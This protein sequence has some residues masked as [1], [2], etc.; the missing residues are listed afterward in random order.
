[1]VADNSPDG[2]YERA[3]QGTLLTDALWQVEGGRTYFAGPLFY[4]GSHEHGAPVYLAGLYGSFGLRIN[5]GAWHTVRSA[6]IPA[7]VSH[8]LDVGGNPISVLYLDPQMNGVGVLSRLVSGSV[9]SEG[10]LL[11]SCTD[12]A[13]VRRL[14]DVYEHP[15]GKQLLGEV[16]NE[17]I[18]IGARKACLRIDPRVSR[19]IGLLSAPAERM[20]S[21]RGVAEAVGLSPSRFQYLFTRDV[22]VP[23]RRYRAWQRMRAAIG[24]IVEGHTFSRAAHDAGF[25]DQAHF[26]HDFK[27]TFGAPAGI[28]LSRVRA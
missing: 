23:F 15:E 1:M 16:L 21:V 13:D 5:G 4:N 27:R 9:E 10:C 11:G 20:G 12:Y 24:S 3:V 6:M 19:A 22:G 7:G 8:E 17:V 18:G 14:R 28:S 2:L 25:S 26:A